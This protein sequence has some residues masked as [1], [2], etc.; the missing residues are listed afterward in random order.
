MGPIQTLHRKGNHQKNKQT[1]KKQPLK[2][3]VEWGGPQ[4]IFVNDAAHKLIFKI[5]KQLLKFNT[6]K[7][8]NPIKN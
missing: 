3:G 8:S 1:N 2:Q 7:T 5:Y 4:E 6:K